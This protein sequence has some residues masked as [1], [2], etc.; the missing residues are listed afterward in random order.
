MT[1]ETLLYFFLVVAIFAIIWWGMNQLPLP[2]IART[3]IIV[4]MSIIAV[5]FLFGLLT[6]NPVLRLR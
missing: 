3:V 4:V 6:G 2:P 1:I 5:I